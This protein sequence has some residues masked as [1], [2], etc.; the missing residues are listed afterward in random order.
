MAPW[1]PG[2]LRAERLSN[3]LQVL[4]S[5][6]VDSP[7]VTVALTYRVGARD[8]P[9]GSSGLA[10]FLEH[11]M[12]KGSGR[13]P[14]GEVDRLTLAHGGENNAFTGHDASTYFFSFARDRWTD[15]LRIEADRMSH[16][17]LDR[18]EVESER[19]VILEEIAMYQADPWDALDRAVQL[20]LYGDHPYGR[21]VLGTVGD[22]GAITV[23]T[24]EALHQERYRPDGAVLVMAGGVGD[25]A[26]DLAAEL[27]GPLGGGTAPRVDPGAPQPPDSL[28]RVELTRGDVTRLLLALPA[29][30]ATDADFPS[31]RLLAAVLGA[32]RASRLNRRLVDGGEMCVWTTASTI[33]S[34]LPGS[35]GIAA[36]LLPGV[37]PNLV[38]AAVLEELEDLRETVLENEDLERA[39]RV[40]LADFIFDHERVQQQALTLSQSTALFTTDYA[41]TQL[42]ALEAL[43]A[44]ELREAARRYLDPAEGCVLG[45]ARASS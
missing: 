27:F 31:L 23:E 35:L 28:T 22:V 43:D 44:G 10:H 37:D 32:G 14:A 42:E 25:E 11:M 9:S 34:E 15:A 12:F 3:G 17:L 7:V 6:N 30:A 2:R 24:L 45:W 38:E 21:P 5:E 1:P 4:L 41:A 40:L 16:L 18:R 36:E 33:E 20:A 13:Y 26:I 39:R 8:D 19:A 29:C